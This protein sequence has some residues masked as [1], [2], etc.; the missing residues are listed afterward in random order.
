MPVQRRNGTLTRKMKYLTTIIVALMLAACAGPRYHS[1]QPAAGGD[2]FVASSAVHTV[3]YDARY[4]GAFQAYGIY[5][6]WEYT[7]YS[8][9]F[10]PHYFAVWYPPWPYGFNSRYNRYGHGFPPH[11]GQP[12]GNWVRQRN[13]PA[14]AGSVPRP[15]VRLP[16]RPAGQRGRPSTID[17]TDP[18][19]HALRRRHWPVQPVPADSVSPRLPAASAAMPRPSV[20]PF[21]GARAPSLAPPSRPA[22]R[23]ASRPMSPRTPPVRES[24]LSRRD[25]MPYDP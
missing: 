24:R 18:D 8:P 14:P 15:A 16:E 20:R 21:A 1:V 22:A 17:L 6:W 13:H 2:Y 3:H 23:G 5:P 19:G 4:Y 7:Y 12:R 11:W 9:N 10:Y 25:P